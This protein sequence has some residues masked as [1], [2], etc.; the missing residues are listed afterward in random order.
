MKT[1][2]E[3]LLKLEHSC[4]EVDKEKHEISQRLMTLKTEIAKVNEIF[5]YERGR[6]LF[7]RMKFTTDQQ[8]H[9]RRSNR[10]NIISRTIQI[11][12]ERTRRR[13]RAYGKTTSRN[14]PEHST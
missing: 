1:K 7:L 14:E 3:K 5:K 4:T 13:M 12:F 8:S 11:P 6:K 2:S 10:S 9:R